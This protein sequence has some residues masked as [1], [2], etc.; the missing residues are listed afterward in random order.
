MLEYYKT[1]DFEIIF[2]YIIDLFLYKKNTDIINVEFF[3][4]SEKDLVN[5][6][7]DESV[8]IILEDG[9]AIENRIK[10]DIIF[11]KYVFQCKTDLE[12]EKIVL[13]KTLLENVFNKDILSFFKTSIMWSEKVKIYGYLN[14]YP[15]LERSLKKIYLEQ[16]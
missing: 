4:S 3:S 1:K 16:V 7:I 10:L 12:I 6:F 9:T 15:T 11:Y 8:F 13:L 14:L 5:Q 2:C